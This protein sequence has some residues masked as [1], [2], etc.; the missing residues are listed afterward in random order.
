M[1]KRRR[2]KRSAAASAAAAG[3]VRRR[4]VLIGGIGAAVLVVVAVLIAVGLGLGGSRRSVETMFH[5]IQGGFTEEG[6]PYLGSSEADVVL[7]EFTDFYCSHCRDYNLETEDRFLEDYVATGKVRYVLHYYSNGSPQSLQA[8]DAAMCAAY[9]GLY[10]QFQ[11]AFFAGPTA[12]REGFIALAHEL[13]LDEDE[14][15]ACWDAGRHRN[16]LVG[17][18]QAAKAMGI[19]ATP[20]FL[21]NDQLIVGND[22]DAVR[23]A[24]EDELAAD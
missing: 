1:G 2:K 14:F 10:F 7:T 15:M 4:K 12:T 9:Q 3:V 21:V 18:I 8:T 11:R 23:Q 13:G 19:S 20:S 22:P 24:I 17:H 6:F 16:A 5:E